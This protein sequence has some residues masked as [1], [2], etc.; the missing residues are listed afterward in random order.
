MLPGNAGKFES[1]FNHAERSIAKAVHDPI[2]QGTVV[3]PNAHR[4]PKLLAQ[5]DERCE[6]F[7]DP[8]ELG[9]VLLI[10]VLLDRKLF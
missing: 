6:S 8:L 10:G 9:R 5:S 4:A 3:C 2:A 7:F 1:A